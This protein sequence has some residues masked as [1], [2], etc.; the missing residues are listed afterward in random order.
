MGTN[1]SAHAIF[2]HPC[3]TTAQESYNA[4]EEIRSASFRREGK[5]KK[6]EDMSDE[7]SLRKEKNDSEKEPV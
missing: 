4:E 6:D 7:V 1:S 3:P 5:K 2:C